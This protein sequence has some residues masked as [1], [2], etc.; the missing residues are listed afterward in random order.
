MAK[1][2]VRIKTENGDIEIQKRYIENLSSLS[3]STPNSSQII[4]GAVVS[5]GTINILDP[6]LEVINEIKEKTESLKFK[7]LFIY[8]NDKVIQE[9]II[10][11]YSLD[12]QNNKLSLT[13]SDKILNLSKKNVFGYFVEEN[14]DQ[15]SFNIYENFLREFSAILQDCGLIY[16]IGHIDNNEN[17]VWSDDIIQLLDKEVAYSVNNI[18]T[19]KESLENIKNN[20]SYWRADNLLN[21]LNKIC[22]IARLS[23]YYSDKLKVDTIRPLIPFDYNNDVIYIPKTKQYSDLMIYENEKNKVDYVNKEILSFNIEALPT[24]KTRE[25]DGQTYNEYEIFYSNPIDSGYF[26]AIDPGITIRRT[27]IFGVEWICGEVKINF[28]KKNNIIGLFYRIEDFGE[29]FAGFSG[30]GEDAHLYLIKNPDPSSNYIDFDDF[31]NNFPATGTSYFTMGNWFKNNFDDDVC[32]FAITRNI[33]SFI[34]HFKVYFFTTF[35]NLYGYT[36]A[37][38]DVKSPFSQQADIFN[39]MDIG[40]NNEFLQQG[41]KYLDAPNEKFTDILETNIVNDRKDGLSYGKITVCCGDYHTKSGKF[42]KNFD[43]GEILQPGDLIELEQEP[44]RVFKITGRNFK[45]DGA[46]MLDLEFMEVKAVEI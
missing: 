30:L 20:F 12:V 32:Y 40:M 34:G 1:I 15:P 45:Y 2:F 42:I 33:L 41:T 46:P 24:D 17:W 6:N 25:I 36:E 4:Y 26:F 22:E 23:V 10:E 39:I 14:V 31:I 43:N 11:D 37:I 19:I 44:D 35:K 38:K 9:H 18:G 8:F 28:A 7:E 16:D 27:H 5:R 3:Q 21:K 13:L 29:D